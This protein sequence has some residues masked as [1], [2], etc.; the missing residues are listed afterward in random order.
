MKNKI[1][2]ILF[3]LFLATPLVAMELQIFPTVNYEFRALA[4]RPTTFALYEYEEYLNDNFAFKHLFVGL[5]SAIHKLFASSSS[6]KTVLGK[7]GWIFYTDP[8]S[9]AYDPI[10]AYMGLNKFTASELTQIMDKLSAFSDKLA[11][12][13]IAFY[14]MIPPNKHTVYA[15]MLPDYIYQHGGETRMQQL[16]NYLKENTN[17]KIIDISTPL[18]AEHNAHQIYYKT[19]THWND[20]GAFIA[21]KELLKTFGLTPLDYTT[22]ETQVNAMDLARMAGSPNSTDINYKFTS[23]SNIKPELIFG[24]FNSEELSIYSN[25]TN[26]TSPSL[27][28]YHDSYTVALMPFLTPHFER[29]ISK[30]QLKPN[31]A[32]V[33]ELKPDIVVFQI[34]ERNLEYLLD[35]SSLLLY[36]TQDD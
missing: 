4:Q 24:A 34:L 28:I 22:Q 18:I 27:M 29:T 33:S 7:D 1:A 11:E 20:Y 5:D 21:H 12:E 8:D 19:D 25:N 6:T 16:A 13:G 32:E 36:N 2:I 15:E 9:P 31:A 35:K 14:L 30:W 23:D 3:I 26:N 17:V 10:R